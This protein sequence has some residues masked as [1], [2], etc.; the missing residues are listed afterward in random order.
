M[1]VECELSVHT[2]SQ[3]KMFVIVWAETNFTVKTRELRALCATISF[4]PRMI[5]A[6]A[7]RQ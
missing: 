7:R 1:D 6:A 2:E 3:I 4:G 5:W